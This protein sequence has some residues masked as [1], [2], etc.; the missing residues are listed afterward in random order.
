[1]SL[2]FLKA[3]DAKLE[4]AFTERPA[5]DPTP[6]RREKV[7]ARIDEA[8]A[9]LKRGES[10][11][12][13]GLYKTKD[14]VDGVEVTLKLGSRRLVL[15]RRDSWFVPDATK[16][17]NDAKKAAQAGDLDDAI[18]ALFDGSSKPAASS[19]S[20]APSSTRSEAMKAA[21]AKRRAAKEAAK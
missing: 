15:D 12:K 9:Q 1:M 2:D 21:W 18:R 5:S 6:K 10:K 19:G 7:I 13:N 3:H 17:Y 4:K 8:L 14:G 11:P 16:F 20:R